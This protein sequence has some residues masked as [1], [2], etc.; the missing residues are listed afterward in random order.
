MVLAFAFV[1]FHLALVYFSVSFSVYF[2]VYFGFSQLALAQPIVPSISS[3]MFSWFRLMVFELM[4]HDGVHPRLLYYFDRS[5]TIFG[6]NSTEMADKFS[7][8][9]RRI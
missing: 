3:G 4:E 8:D 6:K 2:P 1:L 9:L 7:F 5:F